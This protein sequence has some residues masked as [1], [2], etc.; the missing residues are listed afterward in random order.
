MATIGNLQ[1]TGGHGP[2][3][4]EGAVVPA[5]EIFFGQF[6]TATAQWIEP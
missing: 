6:G 3:F 1:Q 2:D 4:L 5:Y